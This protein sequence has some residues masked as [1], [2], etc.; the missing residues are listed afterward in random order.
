[1]LGKYSF[2]SSQGGKFKFGTVCKLRYDDKIGLDKIE[3]NQLQ[4]GE[5]VILRNLCI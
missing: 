1:M 3:V 4:R 5:K 2:K